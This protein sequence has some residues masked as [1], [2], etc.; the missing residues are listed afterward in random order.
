MRNPPSIVGESLRRTLGRLDLEHPD[1]RR[2]VLHIERDDVGDAELA[3][4]A[5]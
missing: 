4:A 1:K 5:E 3:I 2:L